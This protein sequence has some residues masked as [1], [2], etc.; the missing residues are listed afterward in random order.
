M[1]KGLAT[2][3]IE[4]GGRRIEFTDAPAYSEKN[5]GGGFP[6]KWFWVQ[7]EDFEDEPSV[8]LTSVGGTK[9]RSQGPKRANLGPHGHPARFQAMS[10]PAWRS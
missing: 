3:W 2:G 8:T 7:C 6:K 4:W 10:M 5:W 1:A 9:P